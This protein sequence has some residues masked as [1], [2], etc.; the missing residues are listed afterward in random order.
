MYDIYIRKNLFIAN[1]TAIHSAELFSL[2]ASHLLS[3]TL[4]RFTIIYPKTDIQPA[5]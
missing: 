1:F 4:L 3:E 2:I 5:S